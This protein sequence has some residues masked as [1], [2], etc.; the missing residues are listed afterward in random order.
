MPTVAL[1]IAPTHSKETRLLSTSAVNL[2]NYFQRSGVRSYILLGFGARRIPL[3]TMLRSLW[4]SRLAIFYYGH[5]SPKT[6]IGSE[7]INRPI[8]QLHLITENMRDPLNQRI[9]RLLRGSIIYTVA[10]DS[11]EDL[12]QWLV[13]RG[14]RAF[15]GSSKP[16]WI[17]QDLDFDND[18]I[19]DMTTILTYGPRRLLEGVSLA[20]A[21]EDYRSQAM[22]MANDYSFKH[23]FPELTEIMDQNV[24]Y[25]RVIGDGEWKWDDTADWQAERLE[26][27]R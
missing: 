4:G 11:A 16:M 27:V 17:T 12:G 15:V 21:V 23:N 22:M 26:D 14:V 3:I 24:K 6:L 10:C 1:I 2:H 25:Y 9:V 5:G 20:Q 13:E 8:K 19:P 18:R 7:L